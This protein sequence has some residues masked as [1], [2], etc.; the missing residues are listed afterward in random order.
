MGVTTFM[1]TEFFSRRYTGAV[2]A[3]FAVDLLATGSDPSQ[4]PMREGIPAV[5][6]DLRL[7][8]FCVCEAPRE[9]RRRRTV[10]LVNRKDALRPSIRHGA[11][12]A[13]LDLHVRI[14]VF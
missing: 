12:N 1:S 4:I 6:T 13:D 9:K 10:S 8:A 7:A 5:E 14:F 2:E 11:F 3:R